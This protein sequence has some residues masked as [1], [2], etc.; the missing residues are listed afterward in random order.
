[1]TPLS[2]HSLQ[3]EDLEIATPGG[4]IRGCIVPSPDAAKTLAVVA[5]H[6]RAGDR[7]AYLPHAAMLHG[8]A[9]AVALIDLRENGLSDGRGRG[10]ALAMREAEDALAVASELRRRGYEKIVLLGCSLGGSAVLVAAAR[11]SS[12]AG[13]I[14]ENPIECF[15][16]YLRDNL[17][18]RLNGRGLS[19]QWASSA[20]GHLV[21]SLTRLRLGL[22]RFDDPVDVIA[23]IAPR[24]VLVIHEE[25]DPVVMVAHSRNLAMRAGPG[26]RLVTFPTAGHCKSFETSPIAFA[27]EVQRLLASVSAD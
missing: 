7:T 22:M 23:D 14:A 17:Q 4:T 12:I 13:V 5:I 18:A 2:V 24:P 6:G 8:A 9:A 27:R 3:Y 21:V 10:T 11:D 26:A 20:W 25:N 19:T 15:G 16:A 1:M